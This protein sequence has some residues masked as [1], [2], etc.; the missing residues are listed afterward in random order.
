MD[1]M[2]VDPLMSQGIRH[3][4]QGRGWDSFLIYLVPI[5][6]MLPKPLVRREAALPLAAARLFPGA[7]IPEDL[8]DL[9]GR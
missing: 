7:R 8:L 1:S 4:T 6:L 5:D 3:R 2:T 9:C